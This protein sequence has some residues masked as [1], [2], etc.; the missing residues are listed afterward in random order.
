MSLPLKTLARQRKCLP[1]SFS[2]LSI[3][4]APLWCT[5][6]AGWCIKISIE[7]RAQYSHENTPF[8]SGVFFSIHCRRAPGTCFITHQ[9]SVVEQHFGIFHK[10]CRGSKQN[11]G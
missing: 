1:V 5:V 8:F 7:P 2:A 10:M 9:Q 3:F 6:V 11:I 4:V